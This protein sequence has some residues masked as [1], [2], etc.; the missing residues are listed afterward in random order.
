MT[1]Q[2][3]SYWWWIDREEE[4]LHS[5]PMSVY[6]T[7]AWFLC[8]L[9]TIWD[10]SNCRV[11]T[12]TSN[13]LEVPI[14]NIVKLMNCLPGNVNVGAL[15]FLLANANYSYAKDA[16]FVLPHSGLSKHD[17]TQCE[18]KSVSRLCLS[19]WVTGECT[20]CCRTTV[21]PPHLMSPS[22]MS[23]QLPSRLISGSHLLIT[24]SLQIAILYLVM[25]EWMK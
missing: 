15:T 21:F 10:L 1:P 19:V 8:I 4:H 9:E 25:Y 7:A 5:R 20:D 22:L 11:P 12:M 23:S 14:S 24:A 13:E 6:S 16:V 3:C 2:S 17:K 18:V